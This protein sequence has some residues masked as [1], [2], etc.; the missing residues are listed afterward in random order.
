MSGCARGLRMGRCL[1]GRIS[2]CRTRSRDQL[3]C[4]L[5]DVAVQLREQARVCVRGQRD[6]GVAQ[7]LLQSLNAASLRRSNA[8]GSGNPAAR[9]QRT[10]RAYRVSHARLPQKW[11][12]PVQPTTPELY[13]DPGKAAWP[14]VAVPGQLGHASGEEAPAADGTVL[15][16]DLADQPAEEAAPDPE[17]TYGSEL[18]DELRAQ[19]AQFVILPSPEALDAVTL[20]APVQVP[21]PPVIAPA[22][23][24][25]EP[26]QPTEPPAAGSVQPTEPPGGALGTHGDVRRPRATGRPGS[27]FRR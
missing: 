4:L 14:A 6:G 24:L 19:I 13:S 12:R 27:G 15:G 10:I 25:A 2:S 7:G 5:G 11:S 20:A 9:I 21:E 8:G 23:P 16:P 26:V 22:E 3:R 1:S 17:P 18:L